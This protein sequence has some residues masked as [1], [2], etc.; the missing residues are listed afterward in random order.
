VLLACAE[1]STLRQIPGF[2]YRRAYDMFA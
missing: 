1:P 2:P